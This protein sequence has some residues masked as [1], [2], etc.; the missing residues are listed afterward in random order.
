[1]SKKVKMT[2]SINGKNETAW[3]DVSGAIFKNLVSY[4]DYYYDK[5]GLI[6]L[7]TTFGAYDKDNN[8]IDLNILGKAFGAK[9]G[10]WKNNTG[11]GFISAKHKS[12]NIEFMVFENRDFNY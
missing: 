2:F 5:K 7:A 10:K 1:M 9:K 11:Y 3:C 8:I 12:S 4:D 6:S